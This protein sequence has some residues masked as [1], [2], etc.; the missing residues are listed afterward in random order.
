[1]HPVVENVFELE[2]IIQEGRVIDE[3]AVQVDHGINEILKDANHDDEVLIEKFVPLI[4]S[5]E[6]N[7]KKDGSSNGN[8]NK[9]NTFHSTIKKRVV[10]RVSVNNPPNPIKQ[11]K[12]DK[13]DVNANANANVAITVGVESTMFFS[14][15]IYL[16]VV[17]MIILCVGIFI[18]C[19][20]HRSS[21]KIEDSEKKI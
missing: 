19:A 20:F 3:G 9:I 10:N 14:R 2:N 11:R 17:S 6:D 5:N 21:M 13:F 12:V 15:E 16:L 7:K 1:M 8:G 18:S 4:E